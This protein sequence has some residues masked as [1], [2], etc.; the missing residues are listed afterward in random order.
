MV[1]YSG[2]LED[3]MEDLEHPEI[4]Q[5][6]K[7]IREYTELELKFLVILANKVLVERG[8]TGSKS[9]LIIIGRV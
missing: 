4:K 3:N 8:Q 5:V 6:I 7:N 9:G 1:Y 2:S